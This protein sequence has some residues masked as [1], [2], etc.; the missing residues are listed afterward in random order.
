[1]TLW[2]AIVLALV[3]AA[4]EFLPIS[5]SGHLVILQQLFGLTPPPVF[6]DIMIHGGTLV[7]VLVYFRSE[8]VRISGAAGR[9]L[10]ALTNPSVGRLWHTDGDFRLFI[11]LGVGTLPAAAFGIIVETRIEELFNSLL[12][13]G[14][15]LL[16][17][18]GLLFLTRFLPVGTKTLSNIGAREVFTIGL[19]QAV[20]IFPGVSRSGNTIVSGMFSG[21]RRA[22]AFAFSF[23][24]SVPAIAGA[25]LLRLDNLAGL[26]SAYLAQSLLGAF[27]SG[28]FGYL[29]LKILSRIVIGGKLFHFGW[30]CA[31][32]GVALVVVALG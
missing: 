4:T 5:S 2:Q 26:N 12:L 1:M 23:L 7:A 11:W 28:V 22:D 6:F 32:L 21:L 24:L 20:A 14:I 30:Y 19:L 17:T 18:A 15:A 16:A 25:I 8:L 3:Q 9:G 10:R 13:V 31:I 27:I 29:A